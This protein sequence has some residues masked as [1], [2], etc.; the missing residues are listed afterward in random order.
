MTKKKTFTEK[1][2][3]TAISDEENVLLQVA[4][5]DRLRRSGID[6]DGDPLA[7]LL[8]HQK[9]AEELKEAEKADE[10]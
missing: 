3:K 1:L 8:Q 2:R 5:D 10:E 7:F 6:P 9:L 4:E